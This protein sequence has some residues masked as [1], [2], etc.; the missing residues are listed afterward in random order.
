MAKEP[1]YQVRYAIV[2]GVIQKKEILMLFRFILVFFAL[3]SIY[4]CTAGNTKNNGLITV[5][6][7]EISVLPEAKTVALVTIS[8]SKIVQVKQILENLDSQEG[9]SF[10]LS[11]MGE[12]GMMLSVQNSL[13]VIVKYDIEMI[14]Y[15]RKRHYTSSCPLMP[16]SG[17]FESWGH[18]IPELEISN[19]RILKKSEP[20]AC[21]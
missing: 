20:M 2:V 11:K 21:Q 9:I 10:S 1:N 8:E 6:V 14:D 16:G 7:G 15:K 4:G 19:F 18:N 17:V 12:N 13:N 5:G 3:L